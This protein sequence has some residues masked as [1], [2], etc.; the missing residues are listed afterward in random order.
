MALRAIGGLLA[1]V[2]GTR[3][4]NIVALHGWGRRGSDF[5]AVLA[6]HDAL[7][8]DLPGFGA[9]PRPDRALTTREYAGAVAAALE[10]EDGGPYVVVGHSFGGRV[11]VWLA[12]D[13][14]GLVDR[15][16]LTG[17]PL[18]RVRPPARPSLGYRLVRWANRRGIVSDRRMERVRRSRGSADYLAADGVMRDIMVRAVNETY[19]EPLGRIECPVDLVWGADDNEVPPEVA[20]K[21]AALLDA[22]GVSVSVDVVEGAGHMVPHERP[23]KIRRLLPA[24]TR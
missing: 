16:V 10:T 2:H 12:A 11:A 3:R 23:E 20:T 4:P 6:G 14:P 5:D 19:E 18:V 7:A 15:L 22:A 13:H 24:V 17:V 9:T 1:A 21:A 8:F